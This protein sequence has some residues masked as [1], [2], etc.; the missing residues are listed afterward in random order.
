MF[1]HKNLFR[2]ADITVKLVTFFRDKFDE[3]KGFS[4][5][6]TNMTDGYDPPIVIF[7]LHKH[8]RNTGCDGGWFRINFEMRS[9]S[10]SGERASDQ[11]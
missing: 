1:L 6:F 8:I 4:S 9:L 2:S 3:R 11:E 10:G 7:P 5:Q